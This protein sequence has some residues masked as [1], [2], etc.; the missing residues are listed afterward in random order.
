MAMTRTVPL[1]LVLLSAV[2]F[3]ACQTTASTPEAAVTQF[4]EGLSRGDQQ[5]VLDSLCPANRGDFGGMELVLNFFGISTPPVGYRDLTMQ[6]TMI[7][8][9][10]ADVYATGS[11]RLLF[12]EEPFEM[13]FRT[14]KEGGRWYVCDES[15]P[16][17]LE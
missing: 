10:T 12:F 1:I 2:S 3:T 8:S 16:F 7:D 13:P 17:S 14:V 9:T 15:T 5:V 4:F 6:T 11:L